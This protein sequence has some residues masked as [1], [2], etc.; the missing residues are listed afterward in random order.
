AAQV[1][2]VLVLRAGAPRHQRRDDAQRAQAPAH[3]GRVLSDLVHLLVLLSPAAGRA[4]IELPEPP[5][6]VRVAPSRRDIVPAGVAAEQAP[7]AVRACKLAQ[8]CTAQIPPRSPAS[9]PNC[10]SSIATSTPRSRN[11]RATSPTTS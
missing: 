2:V 3:A 5:G 4:A 10:G 9:W 1:A 6:P 8:E 7:A 11:C